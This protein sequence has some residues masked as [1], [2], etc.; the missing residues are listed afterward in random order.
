MTLV[1]AQ[2]VQRS[3][4][5]YLGGVGG[6]HQSHINCRHRKF[7]CVEFFVGFSIVGFFFVDARAL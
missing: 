7:I 6:F 1:S 3:L 4:L 5:L 2:T